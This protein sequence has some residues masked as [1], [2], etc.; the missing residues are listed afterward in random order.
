MSLTFGFE[1]FSLGH[2]ANRMR[3]VVSGAT[4]IPRPW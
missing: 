1:D 2:G 3:L 4:D